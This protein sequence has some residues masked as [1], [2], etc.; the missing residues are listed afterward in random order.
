M[1]C[2]F[3]GLLQGARQ[4]GF[5]QSHPKELA[6]YLKKNNRRVDKIR[7]NG[8]VVTSKQV[9]ENFEAI[10][11]Y[12]PATIAHGYMCSAF[13][14]LMFLYAEVF[15][16]NVEHKFD[17]CALSYTHIDGRHAGLIKFASDRGHFWFVS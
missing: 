15:N 5:P 17:R 2:V 1:S 9:S 8:E 14:P 11:N 10:E 13:D 6:L 12:D 3:Q 16:V 7:W 4:L